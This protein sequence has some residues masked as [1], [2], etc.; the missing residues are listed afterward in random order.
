MIFIIK[1]VIAEDESIERMYIRRLLNR[2]FP[3]VEQVAEAESGPAALNLINTI[4]PDLCL[5]DIRMPGMD[6]LKVI[7]EIRENGPD[8]RFIIIS[9]HDEFHYA[10]KAVQL[11][12]SAYLLKPVE[13][14]LLVQVIG[15]VIEE[16]EREN[17]KIL[18]QKRITELLENTIPALRLN[19]FSEILKGSKES[20]EVLLERAR[21]LGIER[22]PNGV[23]CA[24]V[25]ILDSGREEVRIQRILGEIYHL[26]KLRLG[27]H[28]IL[29]T[30]AGGLEFA[31]L[32]WIDPA[33]KNPALKMLNVAES[34]RTVTEKTGWAHLTIGVGKICSG[35][36]ELYHSYRQAKKANNHRLTLGNNQVIPYSKIAGIKLESCYPK[37]LEKEL[38]ARIE[39][40][41]ISNVT[42]I[43][44]AIVSEV[45]RGGDPDQ[46]RNHLIEL[47]VVASRA[48][49]IPLGARWWH[50]LEQ[51]QTNNLLGAWVRQNIISM[52]AAVAKRKEQHNN[53]IICNIQRYINDF[54][55]LDLNLEAVAGKFFLS[56]SYLSRIFKIE[57]GMNF[58]DYVTQVR[59][60]AAEQLLNKPDES[61]AGIAKK[62]GYHDIKYFTRVFKKHKG[63]TPGEYRK[64]LIKL[65]T[66]EEACND[67]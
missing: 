44:D 10:Q 24:S 23:L 55:Y 30:H 33:E 52:A 53:S 18:E 57:T 7:E 43:M 16:I 65:N 60:R 9:A 42:G 26:V 12:A 56:P 1:I 50:A 51:Y 17:N 66:C 2:Y 54:Y 36:A 19:F 35:P 34:L 4:K 22:F 58:V 25:N 46:M 11:G 38:L 64:S 47:L 21:V 14:K 67:N 45:G 49:R 62:A 48:S 41:D 39:L 15:Q 31:V 32:V 13:S 27:A 20:P 6:G 37:H 28:D 59:M 63:I 40:G 3:A 5:M 8:T 61:I 29:L